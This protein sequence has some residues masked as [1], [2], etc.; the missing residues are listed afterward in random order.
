[1]EHLTSRGWGSGLRI[2]GHIERKTRSSTSETRE[3]AI[4]HLAVGH[5]SYILQEHPSRKVQQSYTPV[6]QR[7]LKVARSPCSVQEVQCSA[8]YVLDFCHNR[9][10]SQQI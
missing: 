1:M 9:H 3:E 5:P 8:V 6:G 7:D 2:K 10:T 4:A